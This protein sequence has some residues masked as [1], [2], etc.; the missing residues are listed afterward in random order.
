GRELYPIGAAMTMD[1]EITQLLLGAGMDHRC[2]KLWGQGAIPSGP[3]HEVN[4]V[5]GQVNLT[6]QQPGAAPG[7]HDTGY[8]DRAMF[9]TVG[10]EQMSEQ[11]SVLRL[12]DCE[13]DRH[14]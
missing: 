3:R 1:G 8:D 7:L 2:D 14:G 11:A 10:G 9:V 12:V 4:S 6:R 13:R 5:A